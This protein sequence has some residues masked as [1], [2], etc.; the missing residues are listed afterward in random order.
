MLTIELPAEIE[1][2][3]QAL[4]QATGRSATSHIQEAILE[5]LDD[6]EDLN[7]ARQRLAALRSGET[8]AIPIE[9]VMARYG[10]ED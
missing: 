6:I 8:Q 2:R 5:H 4:A 1:N 9:Q 3:L 10:V 7:L